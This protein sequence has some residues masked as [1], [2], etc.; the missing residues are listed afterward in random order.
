MPAARASGSMRREA[1]WES[2]PLRLPIARLPVTRRA[3]RRGGCGGAAAGARVGWGGPP[4]QFDFGFA[5]GPS[6]IAVRVDSA[7]ATSGRS[8]GNAIEP[9]HALL[10]TLPNAGHLV[11][12]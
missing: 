10:R 6:P 8:V 5:P 7:A 11:V 4:R 3:T 1:G 12:G 9:E 2:R